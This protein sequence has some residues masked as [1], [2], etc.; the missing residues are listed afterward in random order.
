[1]NAKYTAVLNS[2]DLNNNEIKMKDNKTKTEEMISLDVLIYY[3]DEKLN[4]GFEDINEEEFSHHD[5]CDCCGHDDCDCS[6]HDE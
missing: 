3:L 5:G 6:C 4:T 2:E 1:M